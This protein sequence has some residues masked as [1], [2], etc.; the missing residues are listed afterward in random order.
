MRACKTSRMR[1][2]RTRELLLSRKPKKNIISE[3]VGSKR[4]RRLHTLRYGSAAAQQ[5]A[6]TRAPMRS[7]ITSAKCASRA[8]SKVRR[9][10]GGVVAPS[11]IA[12]STR[13]PAGWCVSATNSSGPNDSILQCRGQNA[14][15]I[16]MQL[17]H[18]S[19]TRALCGAC[20]RRSDCTS[21]APEVVGSI[22][23]AAAS[24]GLSECFLE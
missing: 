17:A 22:G 11:M 21:K 16:C 9:A 13:E 5:R 12:S 10:R 2:E 23:S 7:S 4:R 19:S 18:L 14:E 20:R 6:P 15:I 24:R 1:E 3:S 8:R